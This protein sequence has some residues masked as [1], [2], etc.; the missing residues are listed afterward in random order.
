METSIL[1]ATA[2]TTHVLF[3]NG[4]NNGGVTVLFDMYAEPTITDGVPTPEILTEIDAYS[5]FVF[6]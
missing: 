1:F 3:G 4:I 6:A 2:T 5:K